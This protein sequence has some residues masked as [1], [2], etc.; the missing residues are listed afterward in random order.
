M[1][2]A[3]LLVVAGCG[4]NLAAP[5]DATHQIAGCTATFSGNFAET[6]VSPANCAVVAS[7]TDSATLSFTI[8]V[9]TLDSS[10]AV[11]IGLGGAASVGNYT[12][13]TA[14][15]WLAIATQDIGGRQ[16]FYVAGSA[17]AP[18]GS[19]T[20]AIDALDGGTAHGRLSILQYVLAGFMAK[21][22]Q[23]DTETVALEF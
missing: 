11:S 15:S 8:P 21:C 10:L 20:L 6:S 16:C 4:D 22:G 17:S 7:D 13:Q 19:F 23:L 2:Y 14:G 1:R 9:T 3:A 18:H 12:S 5:V